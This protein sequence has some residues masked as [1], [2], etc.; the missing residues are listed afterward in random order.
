MLEASHDGKTWTPF[1]T[2]RVERGPFHFYSEN[3][4]TRQFRVRE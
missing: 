1:Q 2:N 4:D 3:K